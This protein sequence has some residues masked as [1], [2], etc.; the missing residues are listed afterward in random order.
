MT[1]MSAPTGEEGVWLAQEKKPDL[2]L[3][4]LQLPDCHGSEVVTRLR[5]HS[6]TQGIPVIVLSADAFESTREHLQASGVDGFLT[7]PVSL[8]ELMSCIRQFLSVEPESA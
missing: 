4:D 2:V 1:L 5:N 8:S 7:K 3:L 6:V